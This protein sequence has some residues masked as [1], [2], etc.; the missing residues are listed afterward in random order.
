MFC[1]NCGTQIPE[2]SKFC[3][4]CGTPVAPVAQGGTVT[5][6]SQSPLQQ[7]VLGSWGLVGTY[8]LGLFS[9][10][11]SALVKRIQ[12]FPDGTWQNPA[13]LGGTGGTYSFIS[14]DEM[15]LQSPQNVSVLRVK[16]SDDAMTWT[17]DKQRYEFRREK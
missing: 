10:L 11:M 1:S 2:T 7:Q 8:G 16:I 17:R 4:N 5:P 15:R 13:M 12:F 9:P 3:A 14:A 6:S